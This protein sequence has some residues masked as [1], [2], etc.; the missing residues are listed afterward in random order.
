MIFF[1]KNVIVVISRKQILK[2]RS[3]G[4]KRS[5]F[6][7]IFH[8]FFYSLGKI[9]EQFFQHISSLHKYT[10]LAHP[11]AFDLFCLTN[12]GKNMRILSVYDF[13]LVRLLVLILIR[14]IL[15]QALM[16]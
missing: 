8:I 1:S 13:S 5:Y 9:H 6:W 4:K 16:N 11:I 3:L 12:F 14:A 10:Y 7:P 15:E 2:W